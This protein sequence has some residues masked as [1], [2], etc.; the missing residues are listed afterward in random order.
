V[1]TAVEHLFERRNQEF[2][3]RFAALP[4]DAHRVQSA[5]DHLWEILQGPTFYAWLELVV[6]A[7]TDPDLHREV[8]RLGERSMQLFERTFHELFRAPARPN[9]LFDLAPRMVFAIL[10]GMA[11]ERLSANDVNI[12]ERLIA[13][14]KL[15]ATLV[16][17]GE[18]IT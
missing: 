12:Q 10:N 15:L 3:T 14:V 8:A 16:P 9:P 2:R 18:R 4:A 1:L 17:L 7:R 5:V 13:L 11:I 6:A